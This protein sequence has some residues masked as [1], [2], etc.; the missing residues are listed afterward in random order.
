MQALEVRDII[1][2]SIDEICVNPENPRHEIVMDLGENFI[3]QQLVKTRKDAQAMY[4]LICDIYEA[5]WFPQSIV[6]VTYDEQNVQIIL[7][8]YIQ[9]I[10]EHCHGVMWPK[11]DLKIN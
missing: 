4:K 5:G 1:K 6:T 10:Q 11:R 7:E 8:Q 3:M 9:Q 2:L